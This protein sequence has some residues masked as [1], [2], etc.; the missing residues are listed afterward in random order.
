MH[1][2][3]TQLTGMAFDGQYF[4]L[5][6]PKAFCELIGTSVEWT[7]PGW[8]GGHRTELV[9]AD[10][11]KD[12]VLTWYKETPE[13]I[14]EIHS[15]VAYGKNYEALRKSSARVG[16]KFYNIQT[17]C[18]TRFAQAERKVYKNFILN[19]LASVTH[20]QDKVLN[21]KDEER[22]YASKFLAE[23]YKLV[24]V[25]TVLGLADLLIKVKEVSLLQTV[26][27]LPWEVTEK[28][29]QFAHHFNQ[30]YTK[31]LDFKDHDS[32][33]EP[34]NPTDFPMLCK[35]QEEIETMG[36]FMGVALKTPPVHG[37]NFKKAFRSV[38]TS[39]LATWCDLILEH[40][41]TRFL[42]GDIHAWC[43]VMAGCFDLRFLFQLPCKLQDEQGCLKKVYA[44]AK[45][46]GNVSLPS[47]TV[48]WEQHTVIKQRLVTT[49]YEQG[50]YAKW[51]LASGTVVMQDLLTNP[52]FYT[53]VHDWVFLFQHC[54]LKTQNEA[55]VE[56]QGSCVDKHA[57]GQRHLTQRL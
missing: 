46:Q 23:M 28:E 19:Y 40:F 15:K 14:N 16:Q 36:T 3:R 32:V 6:V 22:A 2:L 29:A 43:T 9:T 42:E 35:H 12:E 11:R 30:V 47:F 54:A 5:D 1:Q 49:Y 10:V 56:S 20:F 57:A 34:L 51:Y 26:N 52:E 4:N 41:T 25:V 17:F 7:M 39:R 24:F 53:D 48:M 31:Q 45:E 37:R 38:C 21:G 13:V 50:R 55:V 44:W 27:T 8:D 18:D 33:N